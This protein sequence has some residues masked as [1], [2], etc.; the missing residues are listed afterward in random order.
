MLPELPNCR[1]DGLQSPP[2][3]RSGS[4]LSLPEAD[5]VEVGE[6][7]TGVDQLSRHT[8]AGSTDGKRGRQFAFGADAVDPGVD[9]GLV[10][11]HAGGDIGAG[12]GQEPGFPRYSAVP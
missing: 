11:D 8:S 12:F 6:R 1:D 5:R 3:G 10:D 7:T 4:R 9:R 2:R